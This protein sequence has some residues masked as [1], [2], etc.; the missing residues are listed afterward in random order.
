MPFFGSDKYWFVWQRGAVIGV[1]TG[2]S[3]EESRELVTK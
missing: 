2:K 3:A 1:D